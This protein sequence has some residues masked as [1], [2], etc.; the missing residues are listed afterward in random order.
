MSDIVEYV[1]VSETQE[2]PYKF[3]CPFHR[4]S[5]VVLMDNYRGI[6]EARSDCGCSINARLGK[7]GHY[8]IMFVKRSRQLNEV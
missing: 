5:R 7:T 6:V 3:D 8:T 1:N 2:F 4:K